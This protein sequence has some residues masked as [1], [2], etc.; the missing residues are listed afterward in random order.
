[1]FDNSIKVII[2]FRDV[3][4]GD[5]SNIFEQFIQGDFYRKINFDN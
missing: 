5:Y 1:M 3:Q 2:R 4:G